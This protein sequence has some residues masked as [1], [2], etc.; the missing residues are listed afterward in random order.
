M[1]TQ[2][3]ACIYSVPTPVR[4]NLRQGRSRAYLACHDASVGRDRIGVMDGLH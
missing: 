1:P 2:V 4:T 3:T